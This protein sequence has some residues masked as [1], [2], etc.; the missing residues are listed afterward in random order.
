MVLDNVEVYDLRVA[1]DGGKK[2]YE[3]QEASGCKYMHNNA[4]VFLFYTRVDCS[5]FRRDAKLLQDPGRLQPP[6]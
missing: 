2:C 6:M 3:D 1:I 4:A 5:V